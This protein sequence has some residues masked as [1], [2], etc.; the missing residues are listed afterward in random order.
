MAGNAQK[1]KAQG[2]DNMQKIDLTTLTLPQL[3]QLKQQLEQ[4]SISLFYFIELFIT[5]FFHFLLYRI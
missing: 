3:S 5:A 2:G 1:D 4:V